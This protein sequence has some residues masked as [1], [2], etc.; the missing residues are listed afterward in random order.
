[1]KESIETVRAGHQVGL[2]AVFPAKIPTLAATRVC[3]NVPAWLKF[4]PSV[5]QFTVHILP[6]RLISSHSGG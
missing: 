3:W 5:D 2:L 1:M 4:T 6:E